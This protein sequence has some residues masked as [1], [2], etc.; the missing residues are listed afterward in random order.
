MAGI[1]NNGCM[2]AATSAHALTDLVYRDWGGT[3][4]GLLAGDSQSLFWIVAYC[5]CKKVDMWFPDRP[6][7]L[8]V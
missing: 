5:N 7:R 2:R 8:W 4:C 6:G 1:H 3:Q